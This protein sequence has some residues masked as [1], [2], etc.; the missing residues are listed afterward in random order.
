MS[1]RE[2]ILEC[3][4]YI[5]EERVGRDSFTGATPSTLLRGLSTGEIKN[6]LSNVYGD[7]L[8]KSRTSIDLNDKK[9]K[10]I[11]V[12]II[13]KSKS[14]GGVDLYDVE[15]KRHKNTFYP[16][17]TKELKKIEAKKYN[18]G[19]MM[20]GFNSKSD[21]N[22]FFDSLDKSKKSETDR[23]FDE[24]KKVMTPGK[25]MFDYEESDSFEVLKVLGKYFEVK[26]SDGT[27]KKVDVDYFY[28][29]TDI[30]DEIDD[31]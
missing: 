26:Y 6:V 8:S 18:N 7:I 30:I 25:K 10:G 4:N 27:K 28:D 29:N 13:G 5:R 19:Y 23:I 17:L 3:L 11:Y 14:Y 9:F 20:M 16:D 15:I 21:A 31:I 1:S 24:I 22:K 12:D 2:R